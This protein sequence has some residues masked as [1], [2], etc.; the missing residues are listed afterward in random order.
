M[1]MWIL[2]PVATHGHKP[3][4]IRSNVSWSLGLEFRREEMYGAPI[5][6]RLS[7]KKAANLHDRPNIRPR[8]RPMSSLKRSRPGSL[9]IYRSGARVFWDPTSRR[10]KD[11]RTDGATEEATT[12]QPWSATPASPPPLVLRISGRRS[13]VLFCL[14]LWILPVAIP[15]FFFGVILVP[16][17]D[18]EQFCKRGLRCGSSDVTRVWF[19]RCSPLSAILV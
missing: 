14:R 10:R 17:R 5:P 3:R 16:A 12:R 19:D 1:I 8:N 18:G 11:S 15:S 13:S 9:L 7:D 6:R 2:E 4:Y